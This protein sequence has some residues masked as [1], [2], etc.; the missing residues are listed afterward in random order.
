LSPRPEKAA[1]NA[2]GEKKNP[3]D[4]GPLDNDATRHTRRAGKETRDSLKVE[5]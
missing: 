2:L 4:D 1:E 3:K 5:N